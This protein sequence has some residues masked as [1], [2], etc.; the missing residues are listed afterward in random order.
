MEIPKINGLLAATFTPFNSYGKLNL[1]IIPQYAERLRSFGLAGVFINGTTGENSSLSHQ[2]QIDLIKTWAPF[3]SPEFKV[4][5]MV[6]GTNQHQGVEL[7]ALSQKLNLY[8]ISAN[9]PYYIKPQSVEQLVNFLTPIAEAAPTTPFYFYHI[10]LLTQVYF[11]MINFLEESRSRIPNLAGIK[12]THNDLM[13]L[14]QCIRFAEGAYDI[15]WGWDEMLLAGLTMGVNGGVGSTYNFAAPLY[16]KLLDAFKKGDLE[17]AKTLQ[18]IS[19]DII[20]HYPKYGGAAAGKA[21]M[22]TIGLNLG[23]LRPPGTKLSD[24]QKDDLIQNLQ[25]KELLDFLNY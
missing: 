13:E 9:A 14:N 8:G 2:E 7:A 12:Y 22:D 5:A 25:R 15:L 6:S 24:H 16:I 3:N 19:I 18:E 17:K 11:S 1:D 4:I 23:N 20:S 10:P 21:L